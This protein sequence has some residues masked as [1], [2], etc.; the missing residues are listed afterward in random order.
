MI[1]QSDLRQTLIEL[2]DLAPDQ[3]DAFQAPRPSGPATRSRHALAAVAGALV[4][5]AT[6][7]AIAIGSPAGHSTHSHRSPAGHGTASPAGSISPQARATLTAM[8]RAD[9]AAN[10]DPD[11]PADAVLT[12]YRGLE[13]NNRR[14]FTMLVATFATQK[15]PVAAPAD[16]LWVVQVRGTFGD[17]N[18]VIT[19]FVDG[20]TMHELAGTAGSDPPGAAERQLAVLGPVVHLR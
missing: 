6:V 12:T 5:A 9:A 16:P 7:A 10:G 18:T 2:A 20:T 3:C 13:H 14:Y 11:A 4:A 1:T 8:V 17:G 19:T 15:R